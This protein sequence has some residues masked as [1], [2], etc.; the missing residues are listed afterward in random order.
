VPPGACVE[1]VK[2]EHQRSGQ[3]TPGVVDRILT[4]SAHHHHGIKVMLVGGAVGRVHRIDEQ[5]NKLN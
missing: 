4:N 2:K 1:V 5:E 3:L